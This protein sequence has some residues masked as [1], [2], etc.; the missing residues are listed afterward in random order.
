MKQSSTD[1]PASGSLLDAAALW[2]FTVTLYARPGVAPA[3]LAVQ[4]ATGAR[5]CPLILLAWLAHHRVRPLA[6]ERLHAAAADWHG[7]AVLPLRAVRR[8]LKPLAAE[9]PEVAALRAQVQAVE[10]EAERLELVFLLRQL[11]PV[12]AAEGRDWLP[13]LLADWCRGAPPQAL[14][15]LA[16]A[17]A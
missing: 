15:T 13:A 17:F 16:A 5:I 2:E 6:A 3:C 14:A 1:A 4:E 11:G 7:L 9:A 12:A 10:I 8:G